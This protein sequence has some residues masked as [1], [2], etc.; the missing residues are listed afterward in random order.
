MSYFQNTSFLPIPLRD[1]KNVTVFFHIHH[2][3]SGFR[4]TSGVSRF[5]R[6]GRRVVA[7]GHVWHSKAIRESQR[8]RG[9]SAGKKHQLNI[10]YE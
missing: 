1:H 6:V 7:R 5:D 8:Y 2:M 10:F 3:H 9:S 4:G